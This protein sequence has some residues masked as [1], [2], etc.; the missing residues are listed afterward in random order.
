MINKLINFANI[1]F[2]MVDVQCEC[3]AVLDTAVRVVAKAIKTTYGQLDIVKRQVVTGPNLNIWESTN[4]I[5][6]TF[7]FPGTR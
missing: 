2:R 3:N 1:I 5:L 6:Y 7:Y 4:I